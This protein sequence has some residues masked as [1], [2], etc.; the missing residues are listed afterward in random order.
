MQ[1]LAVGVGV[2]SKEYA[3][4]LEADCG[5]E[6]LLLFT[7]DDSLVMFPAL[8][9]DHDE[10]QEGLDILAECVRRR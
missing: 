2:G 4:K 9:I 8:T 6:G 5:D 1:G 10:M 3:A 7:S